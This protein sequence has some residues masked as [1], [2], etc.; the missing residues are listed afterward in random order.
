GRQGDLTEVFEDLLLC[1]SGAVKLAVSVNDAS[2]A[3]DVWRALDY[4]GR[5]AIAIAM[6]EAGKW[7]RVLGLAHLAP[8]TYAALDA[9]DA[10]APG[11]IPAEDLRDVFRVTELD[12]RTHVYAILAGDTSYSLSPYMH[13]AAFKSAGLNSVFVPMQ[14][15]D[16]D[17]FMRRMVRGAP[18]EVELH[19][20][21][22]PVTNPHK[23]SILRHLD[24]VDET[25][26]KIGAVN[27]VKVENGNLFGYN[28]DAPGFIRPLKDLYGDLKGASAIVVGAGGGARGCIYALTS[29]GVDVTVMARDNS[30]ASSLADEFDIST[31]ALSTD[32]RTLTTDILV[33]AT[34]VGTKGERENET[35]ATASELKGV[36]LV[37]DL[38][39]NP[40]ETRLLRE[41][42]DAGAETLGGV[43]RLVAQG[44]SHVV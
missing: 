35:I 36:R 9:K 29:E 32:H 38:V 10:A 6:G 42:K 28:T 24:K 8:L 41:A 21:G 23:Q 11:Q 13:N 18:R 1:H 19:F 16:L 34:P 12:L 5:P 43:E 33:N 3:V 15:G 37:Y 22:F 25:A 39:Y 44:A 27:T 14:V 30:K 31:G 20:K 4:F 26:S 40:R 7:T 2:E 17:A